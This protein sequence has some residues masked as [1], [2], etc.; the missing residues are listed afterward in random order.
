MEKKRKEKKNPTKNCNSE[1][2]P[3]PTAS[4]SYSSHPPPLQFLQCF[5][6]L[7]VVKAVHLWYLAIRGRFVT[8]TVNHGVFK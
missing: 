7:T 1:V 8:D 3:E 2:E 4:F 5:L 6:S